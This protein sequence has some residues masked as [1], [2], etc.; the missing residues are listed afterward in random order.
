M[1]EVVANPLTVAAPKTESG[2]PAKPSAAAQKTD[3]GG[4]APQP[5]SEAAGLSGARQS[6]DAEPVGS[7]VTVGLAATLLILILGAA[8]VLVR[9]RT[10][11]H[12]R[13]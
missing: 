13:C 1:A 10:R 12:D 7:S 3:E 2:K 11:R 5:V 8:G 4:A 9:H 6:P